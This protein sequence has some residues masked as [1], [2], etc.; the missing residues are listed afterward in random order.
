[1]S[2]SLLSWK[3]KVFFRSS[4]DLLMMVSMGMVASTVNLMVKILAFLRLFPLTVNRNPN[5]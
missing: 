1:M 4:L 3:K 5:H 2:H